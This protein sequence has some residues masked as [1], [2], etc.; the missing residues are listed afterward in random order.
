MTTLRSTIGSILALAL[1]TLA[2]PA[3]AFADGNSPATIAAVSGLAVDPSSHPAIPVV[4][5]L[6]ESLVAIMKAAEQ[7]RRN[8]NNPAVPETP[9]RAMVRYPTA[10]K[11]MER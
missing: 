8:Q 5:S 6:H 1:V 2:A 11:G 7:L 10:M 4:E 9:R 3:A